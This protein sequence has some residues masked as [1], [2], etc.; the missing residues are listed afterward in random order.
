MAQKLKELVSGFIK[1]PADQIDSATPI[2]RSVVKNSILLHRMYARLK[3]E[4]IIVN[5]YWEVKT[6]GDLLSKSGNSGIGISKNNS[7]NAVHP[8]SGDK[9]EGI[10]IDIEEIS[11]LPV[12]SDFRTSPFYEMNFSPGEISY[13]ILQPNPY[14]SFAG[15]F[16]AK[17]AI[18][19]VN[20]SFKSLPFSSIAIHHLESGKPVFNDLHISISHTDNYAVAVAQPVTKAETPNAAPSIVQSPAPAQVQRNNAGSILAFIAIIL[21]LIAIWAVFSR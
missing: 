8:V 3:E 2:D 12:V 14:S 1:I 13:C 5:D 17:E 16:A 11:A 15:I 9:A 7:V 18:I 19:K 6:F 20:N 10:G 21:S 4:N